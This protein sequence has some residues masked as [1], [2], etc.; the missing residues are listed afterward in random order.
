MQTRRDLVKLALG[1]LGTSRL[2]TAKPNSVVRGVIIGAQSYSFRDRSIDEAIAAM[3][4]AGIS[5][6]ELWQGH[7]EPQQ[8]T[9]KG[10]REWRENIAIE[11]F[12]V[13]RE[14]FD[15]AGIKLY[16]YNYS[17]QDDFSDREIERGFEMAEALGVKYIT[18]SAN[19]SVSG[20]VNAY[21]AKKEMF[22]GMHNHDSMKPNEF[23]TPDD[24]AR[25]MLGNS[26]IRVNLDI[27]HFTAAG[28]DPVNYLDK[29]ADFIVTLHLKD[30]KKNHGENLPFGQGDTPIREVLQTLA[31]KKLK[32]PAMI[33]YEYSG[34][35]AVEEVRRCFEF[36]RDA[37]KARG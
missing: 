35:D 24:F 3:S 2:L 9:R 26:N 15:K 29:Y 36:C 28:F 17:F 11:H 27:G 33:E 30:R 14:K 6:C 22:V 19:V 21:A 13:A 7:I 31:A 37:V 32:I 25:A 23:S 16:A 5:Y 20:R 34:G 10:L 8:A 4:K 12:D 1:A 18:A